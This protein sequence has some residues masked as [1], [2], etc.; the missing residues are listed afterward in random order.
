MFFQDFPE[1]GKNITVKNILQ[2]TSGLIDYEDLI[3]DTVTI[4]VKDKDVLSMMM[5]TDSTY[6]EPGSKHK[7]S[8]TGYALLALTVEKISGKPFGE[9][10]N[11]KHFHS[12]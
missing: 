11:R 10:L 5:K 12:T 2:H 4:Q 7:Y 8:N 9:F 1:Y 6:F 3:S